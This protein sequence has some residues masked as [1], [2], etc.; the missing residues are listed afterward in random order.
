MNET[1]WV[2]R[3]G[4][5]GPGYPDH[6]RSLTAAGE[7]EV[8]RMAAWF[9]RQRLA[10]PLDLP[11]L[12][13]G[14]SP[15]RRAQ[16]TAAIM[17]ERLGVAVETLPLITPDDPVEALFDWLQEHAMGAPWLLVSHMPLVGELTGRL[18]ERDRR[19][20]LG[21]PTAAIAA[22]AADVWA[23]GC[24]RLTGFHTPADRHVLASS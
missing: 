9:H 11:P 22:L 12:R 16:Q 18:V 13:L 2:M 5:A 6:E 23:S 21:F 20:S 24:A 1:L 19:A 14:A 3:H 15:Y 4:E 7:R 8:A 17:A 10:D